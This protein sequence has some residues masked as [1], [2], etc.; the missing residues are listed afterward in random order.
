MQHSKV[1]IMELVHFSLPQHASCPRHTALSVATQ[2]QAHALTSC[3]FFQ[4]FVT[5]LS[6]LPIHQVPYLSSFF[7][8][9]KTLGSLQFA[10]DLT[11]IKRTT[12]TNK[13]T[14]KTN[15]LA[16]VREKLYRPSYCHFLAKLVP[17]LADR[18]R[19]VVRAKDSHG[20]I[21]NF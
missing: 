20:R 16:L 4:L 3:S 19:R 15:A 13:Q 11:T 21:L 6:L 12:V 9:Y 1:K 5:I 10:D 8:G 14:T 2:A 7:S 17:T 18:V